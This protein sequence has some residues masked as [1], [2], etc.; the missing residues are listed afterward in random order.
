MQK[1]LFISH[2]TFILAVLL[3]F[4]TTFQLISAQLYYSYNVSNHEQCVKCLDVDKTKY[5]Q[6]Q[7]TSD[8]TSI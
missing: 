4:L 1:S 6:N 7:L 5:C 3:L 8:I 2:K